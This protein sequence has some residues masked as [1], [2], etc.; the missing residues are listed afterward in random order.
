[1]AGCGRPPGPIPEGPGAGQR[2]AARSCPRQ[3]YSLTGAVRAS[4]AWLNA[5]PS[6]QIDD[7]D[8]ESN[9]QEQMD[10]IASDAADKAEE[11]ENDE[12]Q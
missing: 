8:N 4:C 12:N 11:P 7:E 10:E 9:H 5:A 1:M 2:R 6:Y 3:A